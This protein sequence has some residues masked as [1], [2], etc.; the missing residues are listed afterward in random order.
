MVFYLSFTVGCHFSPTGIARY[1]LSSSIIG[2]GGPVMHAQVVRPD[3]L[4]QHKWSGRTVNVRTIGVPYDSY[5]TLHD[6]IRIRTSKQLVC[7]LPVCRVC[8]AGLHC[9]IFIKLR[10]RLQTDFGMRKR[11]GGSARDVI[12]FYYS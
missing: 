12:K 8:L 2:P 11:G 1:H 10:G 7:R 6:G 3:H 4:W 5:T 9:K